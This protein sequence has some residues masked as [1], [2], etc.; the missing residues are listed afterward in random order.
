MPVQILRMGSYE[1]RT[2]IYWLG[3]CRCGFSDRN[4]LRKLVNLAAKNIKER[5]EFRH[6]PLYLC[7]VIKGYFLV[8]KKPSCAIS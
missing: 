3:Y 1:Y 5:D 4:N 6:A 8:N 7:A 2:F